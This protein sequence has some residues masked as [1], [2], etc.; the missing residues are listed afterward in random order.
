MIFEVLLI[1][2]GFIFLIKGADFLVDGAKE[3][4]KKF[5]ISEIVIGLT[6]VSIGTSMPELFVS[7]TSAIEGYSDISIGNIIGSNICNLLFILGL[8]AAISPVV[9]KKQ[10]KLIEMP[11]LIII[12]IIFLIMCNTGNIINEQEGIILI[13]LFIMFLIYTIIIGLRSQNN[14]T[15]I[16][17]SAEE[18]KKISIVKNTF[19]I[20]LGIA[21]L[22]IGGEMVVENAQK[23]AI[24][25]K[26]SE[27]VIGLTI[28]SIGT[29][30]PELVT[31]VTAAIRRDSD[32]AIG[33]I[34][35]SNIF[36]TLLIIGV[37]AIVQPINY[38]I[39][40]NLQ[41][42]VLFIGMTLMLIYPFLKRKNELSRW[43]GLSLV[44]LYI[45]YLIELIV[46]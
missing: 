5:H 13:L 4:A 42:L 43:K 29:S 28:V 11:M 7:V 22:R 46:N 45:I 35:G 44:I 25:L 21:I 3:I 23:I 17:L 10:T 33:N 19:L 36:N 2:I 41:M 20:I 9:F 6:I 1:L 40:Y 18:T 39:T 26:V 14:E 37:A 30:L 16:E 34:I 8:S 38:N 31:S 15:M 27:K 32:I 12:T 24:A